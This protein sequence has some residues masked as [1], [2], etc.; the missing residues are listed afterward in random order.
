MDAGVSPEVW[1]AP[2]QTLAR[3]SSEVAAIRA[4]RPAHRFSMLLTDIAQN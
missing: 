2:L 4:F 1:R 3:A